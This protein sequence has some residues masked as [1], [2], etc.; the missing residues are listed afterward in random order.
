MSHEKHLPMFIVDVLRYDIEQ[1]SNILKLLNSR[2]GVGWR[3]FWPKDFDEEEVF[4]TLKLLLAKGFV[5]PYVDSADGREI[6]PYDEPISRLDQAR[7]LWFGLT[8]EGWAAWENW[9]DYPL[10]DEDQLSE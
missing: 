8:D 3:V 1:I 9:E 5:D 2:G 7:N 6:I 4:Q 10:S